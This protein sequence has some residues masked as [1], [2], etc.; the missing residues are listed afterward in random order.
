VKRLPV[1]VSYDFQSKRFEKCPDSEDL[2]N[3]KEAEGTPVKHWCPTGRMPEGDESRRNDEAGLT[4]VH[5]FFFGKN[6]SC[7]G[8]S[9]KTTKIG[10]ACSPWIADKHPSKMLVAE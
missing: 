4:H 7:I 8:C 6:A 5:H 1:L 2:L 9:S 3:I 10:E